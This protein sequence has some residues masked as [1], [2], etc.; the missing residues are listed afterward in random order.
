MSADL[1]N[2]VSDNQLKLGNYVSADSRSDAAWMPHSARDLYA[3]GISG[4]VD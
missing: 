4:L 2:Y 1:G 3:P